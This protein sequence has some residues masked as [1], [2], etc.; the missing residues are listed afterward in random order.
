MTLTT[1]PWDNWEDYAAGLYR[2]RLSHEGR[3]RDSVRES[4]VGPR[5]VR[6]RGMGND[7]RVA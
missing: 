5:R 1:Q 6:R 7:L 4:P 3:V 2:H